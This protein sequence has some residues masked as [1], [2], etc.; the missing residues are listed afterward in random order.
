[1]I[2]QE[3]VIEQIKKVYDPEIPVNVWDLG[4]IYNIDIHE[5]NVHIKMSL[6]SQGCPSARELPNMVRSRVTEIPEISDATVEIV[7]DPQWNPTLISPEG[8]KILKLDDE[9]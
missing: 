8:R 5:S 2:T 3:Q 6:T 4:L 7:W 1:M 9:A